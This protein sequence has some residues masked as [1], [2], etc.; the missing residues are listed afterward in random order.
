MSITHHPSDIVLVEFANATLDEAY[1]L[2]VAA[3]I[4]H[5]PR[6]RDTVRHLEVLGGMLLD[7][8][9]APEAMHLTSDDVLRGAGD[10]PCEPAAMEPPGLSMSGPAEGRARPL[11]SLY[12]AG[13]WQWI[14]PGLHRREVEV[15]SER[16]VRVFMLRAKGGLALPDHTHTGIEWTCVLEGAFKHAG[17]RFGVGD[18]D[19]ADASVHHE[20]IVEPGPDCVCL[21]AMSG[22][23]KLESR[24]GRLLQPFLRI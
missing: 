16:N 19:E 21:V 11:L 4:V 22:Q 17:G 23:L 3:H 9:A 24:F 20:P 18:F 2:V 14:G 15:P 8:A 10:T 12:R 7:E 6:C 5:C 13:R 1:A